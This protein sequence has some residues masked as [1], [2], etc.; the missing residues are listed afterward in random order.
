M[1]IGNFAEQVLRALIHMG[2]VSGYLL[3]RKEKTPAVNI[4]LA[5]YY[6]V[7]YLAVQNLRILL[8]L[9]CMLA[10]IQWNYQFWLRLLVIPME[11]AL[12]VIICR[13]VRLEKIRHCGVTRWFVVC[14]AI[15]L[16]LYIK[17]S[18]LTM[19]PVINDTRRWESSALYSACAILGIVVMLILFE[20]N[21]FNRE[22][23]SRPGNTSGTSLAR[24]KVTNPMYAAATAL[25]MPFYP[26]KSSGQLQL[27]DGNI[28]T[29]KENAAMHGIGLSSIRRCVQRYGGSVEISVEQEQKWF[30]LMIPLPVSGT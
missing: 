7:L 11:W 8:V 16:Q 5:A 19:Q 6:T 21:L 15:F 27:Q 10:G 4:Y 26:K 14:M 30:R 22:E 2:I 13:K 9:L 3:L 28:R 29:S 23:R 17:W 25:W 12:V 18:L 24:W 20:A 1:S